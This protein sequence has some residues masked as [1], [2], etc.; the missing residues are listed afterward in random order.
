MGLFGKSK[1]DKRGKQ[2]N[3]RQVAAEAVESL[4]PKP[5]IAEATV[6]PAMAQMSETTMRE[7]VLTRFS[8]VVLSL[9]NVPRYAHLPIGDLQKLVVEPLVRNRIALANSNTGDTGTRPLVG[10]AIWASVS[11]AVDKKIREQVASGLFP[12]RLEAD[13]WASG[14]R[15]WLLDLVASSK[16]LATSVMTT[17]SRAVDNKP[18]SLHP[19]VSGMVDASVLEKMLVNPTGPVH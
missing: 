4:A 17:F 2:Q 7:S 18:V 10:I 14:E 13:D 16:P 15:I 1:K 12:I 5:A 6:T 11:D 3:G 9:A 19:M 8:Q